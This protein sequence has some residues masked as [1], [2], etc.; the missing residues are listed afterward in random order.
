MS[1]ALGFAPLVSW[2][3]IAALGG[4]AGLGALYGLVR[5]APGSGLRLFVV[6]VLVLALA[7][8]QLENEKRDARPDVAVVMVD[9]SSS[10]KTSQRLSQSRQA[11]EA[12]R[13]K[14][15]EFKDLESIFLETNENEDGTQAFEELNR[16]L[17]D[18]PAGRLAG[19]VMITDGQIHDTPPP[20]TRDTPSKG[21]TAQAKKF[22]GAPL[23]V[24]LTGWPDEKD[25]RLVVE[26]APAFG[27]VGKSVGLRLRIDDRPGPAGGS[28][29]LTLKLGEGKPRTI[30]MP[31]G[32]AKTV[33]VPIDHGGPSII[34]LEVEAL[35]GEMSLANN[36]ALLTVNG[37]RDRLRVLL[38]S[39]Q[40]HAGERIWRNL[41]KS[42]PSVDLVHFTILRPPD[43]NDFTPLNELALIA[44][45]IRQLFEIK[46][47]EFDLIIFD[48][49]VF[50]FLLPPTYFTNIENYVRR[51]GA[52]LVTVGP[53]FAGERSLFHTPLGAVLPG[54][55]TG[56][57]A[58]G[59]Y[60]AGLTGKGTR[61]PVTALL[62]PSRD[63][64]PPA[65]GRWFRQIDTNVRRGHVLMTGGGEKP[66]LVLD[67]VEKGRVAQ[68]MTDHI[69]LWARGYEGGGPHAELLRRMSHWLMKEPDLEEEDLRAKLRGKRMSIERRTL[70][71]D[72][73]PVTV[74]APSG[75]EQVVKLKP[76]A[77]GLAR[78]QIEVKEN[79]LYSLRDGAH[80]ALA[81]VGRLNAP[82]LMDLRASP[83]RLAPLVKTTGGS[84]SWISQGLP[85]FRRVKL[86]R[87]AHGHQWA[88]LVRNGAYVVVG[89]SQVSLLPPLLLLLLGVGGLMLGWWR[90][91][92]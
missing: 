70:S 47:H 14:L 50:R 78:A 38:I 92:R 12:I 21:L 25:R 51:G 45:P 1:A 20:G 7:N 52:I 4:V 82:E 88:G 40:P 58:E 55:P 17:A 71:P 86:G 90:E 33:Q 24:M 74:R 28:A 84:V 9:N 31:I 10:Q 91:G 36:R 60:R 77:G 39:G 62:S 41:L 46:L 42:D 79:G 63:K 15:A 87:G 89:V 13:K 72:N 49:Y 68:L 76:G 2:W 61:H 18:I 54:A 43:K 66:L 53:D 6:A 56:K 29:R 23:H 57:V 48:R 37:V 81:V 11:T 85:D 44:F 64:K 32:R 35:K 73:P 26:Q 80:S 27:I 30:S 83:E 19:A 5:W 3:L 67:R 22:R 75:A 59:G 8:P 65:W 69:W 16:V 34:Q